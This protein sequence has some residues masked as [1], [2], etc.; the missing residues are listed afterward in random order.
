M[1]KL[2]PTCDVPLAMVRTGSGTLQRLASSTKP[3]ATDWVNVPAASLMSYWSTAKI[4][5]AEELPVSASTPDF[6]ATAPAAARTSS[7]PSAPTIV[8]AILLADVCVER[9]IPC[10]YCH[11]PV[12]CN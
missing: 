10:P 4:L 5:G 7:V 1:R 11:G 6:I 2:L 8:G 9:D 3:P 12:A